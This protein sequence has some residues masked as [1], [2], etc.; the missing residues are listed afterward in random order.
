VLVDRPSWWA[1]GIP[2]CERLPAPAGDHAPS[3]DARRRLARWRETVGELDSRLAELGL[4]EAGLLALLSEPAS[5]LA[6]RTARPDWVGF[7]ENALGVA[8]SCPPAAGEGVAAFAAPLWPLV[9]AATAMVRHRVGSP[10]TVDLDAVL[11]GW[12]DQL[13]H[14]LAGLAARTLVL[15]LNVAR[16]EGRLTGATP[17]ARFA[18]FIDRMSTVDRLAGL[19]AGYPVL[20]KLLADAC[21]HAADALAELILRFTADHPEPARLVAVEGTGGDPHRNG[22]SVAVVRL[23]DGTRIV[24][25]PR[26]LDLDVHFAEVIEW[27]N[28]TVP[29]V[30]L[31]TPAVRRG[32]GHGWVEFVERRECADLAEVDSFYRRLGVLL[33]LLHALD[34]SDMHSENLV[35]CGDTPVL[36]DVETLFHPSLPHPGTAGAD[37]AADALA[38]SV[39]RTALLPHLLI[40]EHGAVDMSGV[41]GDDGVLSPDVVIDWARPGTDEMHLIR[42]VRPLRSSANRPRLRG[43]DAEPGDYRTALLN[44][45]QTGYDAIVAHRDELTGL[46]DRFA[47]DEIRIVPRATQSYAN[48]LDES[49][50]PDV[51]RD[52]LDRDRL[53]DLLWEQSA[54]DPI[55]SR[56]V[57]AELAD[58]WNGDIPL[59]TGLAGGT[60]LHPASGSLALSG[61]ESARRKIA[62]LSEV[63]RHDQ[64]WLITAALAVRAGRADHLGGEVLPAAVSPTLPDSQRLLAAACG[65]ADRIVAAAVHGDPAGGRANWLGIQ[66]V[67]GVHWA[68]LPMGAALSD[69]YSGVALFLAQLADLTDV[70]RYRDLAHQAIRPL[71]RL[72][73]ALAADPELADAVGCGGLNG[74][75]GICYTLARLTTLLGDGDLRRWLASC[76]DLTATAVGTEPGVADGQAGGLAAMLA[77]HAETGLDA[78]H[79]LAVRY[80]EALGEHA[81]EPDG[82]PPSFAWGSTGVDWALSRM[83]PERSVPRSADPARIGWCSGIAGQVLARGTASTDELDQ[84]AGHPALRDMS[85][86][87]G[88][89]G[90]VEA[91]T[92]LAKTDRRAELAHRRRTG[93]LLDELDHYGPRCGTPEEIPTP[94]LLTGLAGIGYGL[95]RAGFP[96]RVP[97]VL[98]LEPTPGKPLNHDER[99]GEPDE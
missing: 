68:V 17:E 87:H 95:L 72:I 92:M 43:R 44:G 30:E 71:P 81:G 67:D 18:D 41:G 86:C 91:L 62:A 40:G 37:P 75:G 97:S 48:L 76:V 56:L 15:E 93:R 84:L 19:L 42:R 57:R 35:A 14:R 24:Y 80:A 66:L 94:G 78:A 1:A 90:V 31:R 46:L 2:L 51:L 16:T 52:A 22:R 32:S 99:T 29:G 33:A 25:K 73:D 8:P 79:R 69:G 82:V 27:L 28:H 88:E 7:I 65:I 20:A 49:T 89:L 58:L 34:G 55:R 3:E 45:F 60:D 5:A 74:L 12:A 53:F 39:L 61:I 98:L 47:R 6:A 23:A 4:T 10:A 85:L 11:D 59:F 38:A 9:T 54:G 70:A 36:V 83:N 13:G 50:H 96:G 64:Q 21:R 63:D 26:S 77:V